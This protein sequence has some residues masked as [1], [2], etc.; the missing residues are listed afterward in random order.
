MNS[1]LIQIKTKVYLRE[2]DRWKINYLF[3]KKIHKKWFLVDLQ[4]NYIQKNIGKME[5]TD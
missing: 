2:Y 4:K 3:V 5:P 1:K